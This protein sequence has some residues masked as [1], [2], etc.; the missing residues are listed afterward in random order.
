MNPGD[1]H[2][3]LGPGKVALGG[4]DLFEL[5]HPDMR[6]EVLEGAV[7]VFAAARI[8]GRPDGERRFLFSA[9]PGDLILGVPGI[10]DSS[11]SL[12]CV[13]TT[14]AR[15]GVG[16]LAAWLADAAHIAAEQAACR[17]AIDAWIQK[18]AQALASLPA[19]GGRGPEDADFGKLD[20]GEGLEVWRGQVL[21][22]RAVS[23]RARVL[24]QDSG[25]LEP[26]QDAPFPLAH[27]LWVQ[28]TEPAG[29]AAVP[30]EDLDFAV[31]GRSLARFQAFL[32]AAIRAV[33]NQEGIERAARLVEREA[34]GQATAEGTLASLSSVLSRIA[35]PDT[36][37][38]PPVIAACRAVGEYL[39]QTIRPPAASEDPERASDTVH[40]IAR[41]SGVRC[42]DVT[43]AGTWY[44]QDAGPLVAF[45]GPDRRPVA[46]LPRSG[47]GYDLVNPADGLRVPLKPETASGL[48]PKAYQLYRS[49][50]NRPSG[51]I[52]LLKLAGHRS[53]GDLALYTV[54]GF[55]AFAFGILLPLAVGV[56][57]DHAVPDS[58]KGL[59]V[60]VCA[61]LALA[62]LGQAIFSFCSSVLHLRLNARSDLTTRAAVWDF[63]LKQPVRFFRQFSA[64]DLASRI[65]LIGQIRRQIGDSTASTLFAAVFA[66]QYL[67]LMLLLAPKLAVV[68]LGF[69]LLS[70]TVWAATAAIQV[71]LPI[72]E[73]L[74]GAV[75][76]LLSGVTKFRV[77][78]VEDLAF[79]HWSRLFSRHQRG[80]L[81]ATRVA[82]RLEVLTD[83]LPTAGTLLLLS[84]AYNWRL[85]EIAGGKGL[86]TGA[87][88][89][90][91]AAFGAF[92]SAVSGLAGA[93]ASLLPFLHQW[94][95]VKPVIGSQ[96]EVRDGQDDPGRLGGRIA[97]DQVTFRYAS[98]LP[99]VLDG[100]SI[101]AEPGE[102]V[103]LVGPSGCGKSTIFRLLLGFEEAESGTVYYDGKDLA[104]LDRRAV[105]R[106]LG[107]VLQNGR[108]TAGSIYDNIACGALITR[109]EAW[110]AARHA[111]FDRDLANLPMG[112]ETVV[113]EGGGNFSGG[114]RQRLLL[115]RAF[116]RKP[117]IMLFDEA[118]SALDNMTQ[119]IVAESLDRLD[120]TR[121]IIAHRLSTIRL[122]DRIYV[123]DKGRVVQQGTFDHLVA[124]GGA[125]GRLVAHQQT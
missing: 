55:V 1:R 9:L 43:L 28:A 78:A 7:S 81:R 22:V 29:L 31:L 8:G 122:C 52:D 106:Q 65:E 96:P 15:L 40:A 98:G 124:Q 4:P 6:V 97:L 89:T 99:I 49:L 66:L 35:R 121:L 62:A 25:I 54:I 95:R 50:P 13:A 45:L 27:G 63:V 70:G 58:N 115:C 75:V 109:D 16:S 83:L 119:A 93:V 107:V 85:L 86:S 74:S 100:V 48:H 46:L 82:D 53:L 105:R 17:A 114:Q 57:I 76:Q 110:E 101:V 21:Y 64:G 26:A 18:L 88:L 23:G 51:P 61:S 59:L 102:A 38:G 120:V 112:L 67:A 60:T 47:S 69:A 125:F 14:E 111:G 84:C 103:A 11:E 104:K 87:F 3:A 56:V 44:R 33:R 91:H 36:E 19:P 5:S 30:S 39:G 116:V 42:R 94:R 79:A 80:K 77:A 72:P 68:A 34:R 32:P 73:N 10:H 92:V 24:G 118:T 117:R 2:L 37:G 108:L 71:R 113:S 12:V 41:A 20:P 123:L 90:F